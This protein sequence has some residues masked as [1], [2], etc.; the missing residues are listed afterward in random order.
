M[1]PITAR[2]KTVALMLESDGPGGAENMLL[3]LAEELR[4]RG[5]GI[6]PVLPAKGLGWLAAECRKRG[7][8]PET[9][10]L[11]RPLDWRCL[12]GLIEVLRRR[13]VDLVHSHEF[14][15][16]FYGAAAARWLHKPHVITMHGGQ[17]VLSHWRRR[18][19]FRWSMRRSRAVAAVSGATRQL[20]LDAL[21]L[22]PD[23]ITVVHNGI[24]P[25]P[26]GNRAAVRRELGLAES[27]VLILSVGNLYPVKGHGVLLEAL[28]QL[29]ARTDL[30]PWRMALAGRGRET[31]RL[32]QF[33]TENRLDRVHFLGH[34]SDVPDIL[35]AADAWVM[36][37][38]SEGL[39][40]ALLEAMFAGKAIVASAVGGIPEAI[41][42][43]RDGLL[44]PPRDP[45]T[46]A[47]ALARVIASPDL[48][49]ALG[50]AAR[51]RAVSG[52]SVAH[53]ADDYERLYAEA[54]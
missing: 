46:L 34:R 37:S 54:G 23:A 40:L 20:F 14:T 38:L 31:E 44:V 39:P 30:P 26:P 29:A 19:A 13:E 49:A 51:E 33:A 1:T 7:F 50:R 22:Q 53:M 9:F 5:Y 52:F 6:C 10:S 3:Q 2:G 32:K 16:A 17:R 45:P 47:A 27:E 11:R 25:P 24:V 18:I 15:M 43:E 8:E 12:Q 4:R 21:H 48:R 35:A 36:P 28:I 42:P 41:V